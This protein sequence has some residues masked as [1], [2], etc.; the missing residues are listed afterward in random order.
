MGVGLNRPS[1]STIIVAGPTKLA[2][3]KSRNYPNGGERIEVCYPC[4]K[5]WER[6]GSLELNPSRNRLPLELRK[7][8]L[9][10]LR[11]GIPVAQTARALKLPYTTV[12]DWEGLIQTPTPNSDADSKRRKTK[13]SSGAAATKT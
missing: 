13:R 5:R 8:A 7:R 3:G 6:K 11:E 1:R 2:N 12:R 4:R 9:K 10:L